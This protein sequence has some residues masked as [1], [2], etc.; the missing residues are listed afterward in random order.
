VASRHGTLLARQVITCPQCRG[1]GHVI[2]RPC[3]ACKAS[4]RAVLEETVTIRI[5]P[6][7]PEG[8]TLRLAGH[9]TPSR[10]P[11][12]PPGDAYVTIRTPTDPRFTRAGAD[13][14]HDLHLPAPDA[15]LGVTTAVPVPGGQARVRVPPGTRPGSVL[16]VAGQGLPRYGGHGRGSLNLTVIPDIPRQLSTRQRQLYEQLRAEDAGTKST[17]GGSP[18]PDAPRSGRRRTASTTGRPAAGR[19]IT[20]ALALLLVTGIFNLAGGIAAIAGSH[21]LVTSAHYASG[22]L[23]AGG[24]AMAIL[25]AVQLLAAAGVWASSQPA[26]WLAVA[27]AGL[28]AIGQMF[29]IP[30]LPALVPADHR[31]G[32]GDAMGA[33]RLRQPREPRCRLAPGCQHSRLRPDCR[34]AVPL[35]A[36]DSAAAA[37]AGPAR[38]PAPQHQQTQRDSHPQEP[39]GASA[40]DQPD[41]EG[42]DAD[43]EPEPPG[44][45]PRQGGP[46]R[47]D[48]H[49]SRSAPHRKPAGIGSR[50][51]RHQA[52]ELTQGRRRVDLVQSLLEFL[53]RQ[54][55]GR[56]MLAQGGR[57]PAPVLIGGS[58]T[59]IPVHCR[60]FPP[61]CR[62]A[63]PPSAGQRPRSPSGPAEGPGDLTSS[64]WAR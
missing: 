64:P 63:R 50:Q 28:T 60:P 19:P 23:H 3:P 48:L 15:A 24:W 34:E 25:G 14:W 43:H 56:V 1:R 51:V 36:A 38:D 52:A 30:R 18:G 47:R 55:P 5:P 20:L 13:L 29:L 61:A 49:R 31:G 57:G 58:D 53:K 10:M 16:R 4:G 44:R 39:R 27:A 22:R 59:R 40:A 6:G 32:D 7:I 41:H 46:A 35:K 37:A 2:D 54:P 12:V 9:G 33:M 8:A 26:R 62:V 11:G 17:T 42:H 21:T 45:P